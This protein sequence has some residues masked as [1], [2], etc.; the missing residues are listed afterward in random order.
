MAAFLSK[1]LTLILKSII[2]TVRNKKI[3]YQKTNLD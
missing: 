2:K 1:N 3:K